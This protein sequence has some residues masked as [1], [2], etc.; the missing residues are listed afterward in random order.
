MATGGTLADTTGLVDGDSLVLAFGAGLAGALGATVFFTGALAAVF[1]A[2][3]GDAL[4]KGL[5]T[6]LAVFLATGLAAGLAI[7]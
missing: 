1:E 2:A 5:A 6:G 7:F 3:F 4:A